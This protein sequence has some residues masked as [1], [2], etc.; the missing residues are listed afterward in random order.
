MSDC[1]KSGSFSKLPLDC[2]L[3]QAGCQR[4][5]LLVTP[6]KYSSFCRALCGSLSSL[7]R[8]LALS[9]GGYGVDGGRWEFL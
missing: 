4:Q 6:V 3:W 8:S 7:K 9:P 1:P 2:S 5:G